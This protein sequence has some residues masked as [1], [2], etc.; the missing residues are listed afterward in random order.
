MARLKAPDTTLAYDPE[1]CDGC[2]TCTEVCPHAVFE[3]NGKKARIARIE[4]CMECGACGLNCPSGA[5]SIDS[6]VGCATAMIIAA[7]TGRKEATCGPD[8]CPG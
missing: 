5:I 8:C 4:D 1:K 7:L 6:G 2:R 3:M